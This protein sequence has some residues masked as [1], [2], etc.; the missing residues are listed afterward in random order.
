MAIT[1]KYSEKRKKQGLSADEVATMLR[2]SKKEI[3]KAEIRGCLEQPDGIKLNKD[4]SVKFG[5]L[6]KYARR[7]NIKLDPVEYARRMNEPQKGI[8]IL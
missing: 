2:V 4:G 8:E 7:H 1:I 5:E 3:L 6:I